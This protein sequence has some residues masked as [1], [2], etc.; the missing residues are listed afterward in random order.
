MTDAGSVEAL[1]GMRRF[2]A[3]FGAVIA[4][5]SFITGLL[6]YF[7]LNQAYWFYAYFGVDAT[8]LGLGTTDYLVISVDSLFV[9]MVVTAAAGL[10]AFWGHDLL[11]TRL[12][13]GGRVR[14]LVVLVPTLAGIGALLVLGGLWSVLD[15]RFFLRAHL[16]AA[17]LSLAAGVVL[18]A[19]TLQL[20]RTLPVGAF[21]LTRPTPADDDADPS[22]ADRLD[23]VRPQPRPPEPRPDRPEWASVAEWAV[24]FVLVGLSLI[25]AAS[26]YAA[27]VGRGRAQQLASQL[28]TSTAVVLRSE[29]SLGIDA[30]GSR[31]LRCRDTKSAYPYRYEGMVLVIQSADQYVLLPQS[32]TPD[33][34]VALVIPR[35]D[36]VRLEF[37][38]YAARGTLG[39]STC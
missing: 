19:Y 20:R 32:W 27:A 30:P 16:A 26:D 23:D 15:D 39:R 35:T 37:V 1:P 25:W 12:A 29:R 5:T 7:G 17:P 21:R 18:L 3:L 11:R 6:Y 9:P 33:T 2:S 8:M 31:E 36:T 4:P 13:A 38:P 24:V 22:E 14:V 10:V 28:A 34:G